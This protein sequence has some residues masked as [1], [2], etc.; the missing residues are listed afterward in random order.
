MT[1]GHCALLSGRMLVQKYRTGSIKR[2]VKVSDFPRSLHGN[3]RPRKR[4][5][6]RPGPLERVNAQSSIPKVI[7]GRRTEAKS[8]QLLVHLVRHFVF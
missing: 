3:P 5:S 8:D 4:Y 1:S 6:G 2:Q 7:S